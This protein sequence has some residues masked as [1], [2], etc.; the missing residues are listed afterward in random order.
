MSSKKESKNSV[1]DITNLCICEFYDIV[2]FMNLLYKYWS[3][4]EVLIIEHQ[5]TKSDYDKVNETII[6]PFLNILSKVFGGGGKVSNL[7]VN[8]PLLGCASF[9]DLDS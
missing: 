6:I 4:K 7:L 9:N 3:Y 1:V 2:Y 8:H 5:F